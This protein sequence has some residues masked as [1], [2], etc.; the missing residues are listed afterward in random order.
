MRLRVV[1]A[2]VAF[3]LLMVGC[4]NPDQ[5]G[6]V[7][8]GG[9]PTGSGEPAEG[10]SGAAGSGDLATTNPPRRAPTL[11][12]TRRP[13]PTDTDPG[14]KAAEAL[15]RDVRKV[16]GKVVFTMPQLVGRNLQQA[17]DMLQAR[18]SYLLNQVDA[19]GA[20]RMLLL[21]SNWKVCSQSPKAGA[22]IP[23]IRV[24]RLSAVKLVESCP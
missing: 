24:V 9:Q 7:P 18:G 13:K 12:P 8:A 14:A 19:S 23:V 15:K 20:G 16:K 21:D 1:V 11:A 22:E 17:Q 3:L 6:A 4:G 5:T 10:T 2:V